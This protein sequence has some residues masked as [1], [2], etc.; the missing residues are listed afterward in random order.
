MT[1]HKTTWNALT[2]GEQVICHA[3]ILGEPLFWDGHKNVCFDAESDL[4]ADEVP[5][6]FVDQIFSTMARADQHLFYID[7][8]KPQRM[9]E[10]LNQLAS[11]DIATACGYISWGWGETRWPLPNVVFQVKAAQE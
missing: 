2:G 5:F 11:D 6:E 1:N 10:Y 9:K 8:K 4:F 7:T 3:E